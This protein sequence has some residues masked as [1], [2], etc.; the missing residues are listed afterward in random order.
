MLLLEFGVVVFEEGDV[1]TLGCLDDALVLDQNGRSG[2]ISESA[3]VLL[4]GS[5][6]EI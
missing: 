3:V 6:V 4:F 1:F 5:S 2:R